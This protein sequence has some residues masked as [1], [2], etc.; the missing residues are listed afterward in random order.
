MK[1]Q[2]QLQ[3]I[4]RKIVGFH[5]LDEQLEWVAVLECGH[6]QYVRHDPP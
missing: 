5:L 2:Q 6:Q 3:G 1:P 4:Q